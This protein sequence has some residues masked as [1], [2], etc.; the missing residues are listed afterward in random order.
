MFCVIYAFTVRAGCEDQF[1]QSWLAVTRWLYQHA[2]SLG[3]RL[4][5]ASTGEY[6]AY[7]QWFS[8]A[9]W[10]QQ[11]ERS[12]AELRL[13]RRAMRAACTEIAVLYELDMTDDW[14]QHA[15]YSETDQGESA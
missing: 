13:H 1:R 4:H 15:V 2:G 5:R 7:A 10:E 8:H 6:I 9:Q 12:D 14:L 11:T 3:S